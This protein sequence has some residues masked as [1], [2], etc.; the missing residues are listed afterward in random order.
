MFSLKKIKYNK[1]F[2]FHN[3]GKSTTAVIFSKPRTEIGVRDNKEKMNMG[4]DGLPQ[5]SALRSIF[6]HHIDDLPDYYRSIPAD[7]YVIWTTKKYPILARTKLK[8]TL[9]Q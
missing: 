7:G 3:D 4:K 2:L 8:R 1:E 6:H 9:P 5:G